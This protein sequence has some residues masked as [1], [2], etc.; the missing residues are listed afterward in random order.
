MARKTNGGRLLDALQHLRDY[1]D[2][3]VV[4][5]KK[6]IEGGVQAAYAGKI[7]V[8]P[9]PDEFRVLHVGPGQ[10]DGFTLLVD[11]TR[12]RA[13]EE[14]AFDDLA[15]RFTETTIGPAGRVEFELF[16]ITR[17]GELALAGDFEEATA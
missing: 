7:V 12:R 11:K 9:K 13:F 6:V 2:A 10:N 16:K 3:G 17:R 8:K 1:G 4:A 15:Y 14:L 5:S